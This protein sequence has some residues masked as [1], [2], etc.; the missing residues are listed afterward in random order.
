MKK[1]LL[2]SGILLVFL[3]APIWLITMKADAYSEPQEALLAIDPDL[4]L[5]PGYNINDRS[6]YFFIKN[7]NQLGAA[8]AQEGLFGWK[9]DRLTW[10]PLDSER[11]YESLSDY[12]VHGENLIYGLIKHGDERTIQ[13]GENQATMLNLAMLP[14]NDIV[15]FRLEELY[16]WYFEN[17]AP[18][19]GE[20]IKL[21]DKNTGEELEQLRAN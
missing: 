9:A 3:L 5:I 16:L 6:L 21:I 19:D 2:L 7:S 18:L 17:D 13:I 11:N 1:W 12:Q 10:G 20:V 15:K 4:L 8:Y 14:P